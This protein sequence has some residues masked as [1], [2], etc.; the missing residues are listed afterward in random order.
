MIDGLK[1]YADYR[2]SRDRWLQA[3]PR[4][5][6]KVRIKYLLREIDRRTQ[7]GEEPL[8]SMRRDHGLV[9][10]SQFSDKVAEPKALLAYKLV[11]PGEL[12]VNRMQA[13]NGL[14][15]VA[16]IPGLISPDY[17]MFRPVREVN[18]EY[19]ELLFRS[20]PMR[21]KFR[22]ESTGLG[23]GTAGFLRLYGDSLG[24][25]EIGLPSL[26]EQLRIVRFVNHA[27][28]Q[29][30]RG[31]RAKRTLL[32]LLGEQRDSITR[33]VFTRGISPTTNLKPS[34]IDWLGDVPGH[35]EVRTLGRISRSFRT[36]PFGS[37]LHQSDYIEGG[38]PLVNP[39]H[40]RGG[41]IVED[42]RCTVSADTVTRLSQYVLD[43]HDIVF[44]RRGEL[45]RCA[46]V[47]GREVGWLCGTGSIRVR[48][49]YDDIDPDYLIEALQL[50]WVGEY[51]SLFSVGATM[52]SLNTAILKRIPVLLPPIQEQR[53]LLDYIAD[54]A[55]NIDR[56]TSTTLRELDLLQECRI[57][58]AA[59]VVTGKIDV[60]EA[61][62]RL[63]QVV[64][65][66]DE[67]LP[68]EDTTE[69][70]SSELDDVD[71]EVGA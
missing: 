57:R 40:M 38:T 42:L 51:L 64:T 50:Q 46:L 63:P 5:W 35:W 58:L 30:R 24:A 48:V 66:L 54:A 44:S 15:F 4:S 20:Y 41:R 16:R 28:R 12:V 29:I 17:A 39:T 49:A 37:S 71:A 13:G 8:L 26:D 25:I 67:E 59:D 21:A 53:Q 11:E 10:L 45:G 31:I 65:G 3:V 34:G 56:T 18:L 7:T 43:K 9:P 19:L 1:P 2:Y 60:R 55:R 62:T 14:V 52:E 36:G 70:D 68:S 6:E 47:R 32:K 61:A 22:S 69:I 23:T 33:R 27:D